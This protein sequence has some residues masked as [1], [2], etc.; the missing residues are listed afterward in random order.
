MDKCSL[1]RA[2]STF[3][4]LRCSS[5]LR[6]PASRPGV[7]P[8]G[9]KAATARSR[10]ARFDQVEF[11]AKLTATRH[12]VVIRLKAEEE[13]WSEAEI[14]G[15]PEVGVG[16]DRPFAEHD[17]V[18][19]ARELPGITVTRPSLPYCS[20]AACF[21]ACGRACRARACARGNRPSPDLDA[22]AA[23]GFPEPVAIESIVAL[24]EE[25]TLPLVAAAHVTCGNDGA[26][27]AGNGQ[28]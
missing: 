2:L 7:S 16:G 8:T 23:A 19:A 21:A 20:A 25:D 13:T 9:F 15:Q 3:R 28:R 22:E 5:L 17:L 1:R 10:G 27:D 14:S 4:C 24:L 11:R 6:N 26:G 18:D 12:Q